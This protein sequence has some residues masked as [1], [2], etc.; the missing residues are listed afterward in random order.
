MHRNKR[1]TFK[2]DIQVVLKKLDTIPGATI[3]RNNQPKQRSRKSNDDFSNRTRSKAGNMNQ[4]IGDRTR[5]KIQ[6]IL[7]SVFQGNVFP[8]HDAVN[9]QNKI[10]ISNNKEV[11]LQLGL[12]ECNV[13]QTVLVHSKSQ[14]QLELL[15]QLHILDKADDDNSWE[16]VKILKYSEE[17]DSNNSV[18]HKCLVEWNDQNKLQS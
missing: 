7:K 3:H 17:K 14:S 15:R 9:F 10:N 12:A 13:Y 16:W 1:V 8:L 2:P 5:P 18:Q 4:N 11:D 6:F